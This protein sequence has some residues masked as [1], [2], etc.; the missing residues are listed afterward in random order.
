MTKKNNINPQV[1][2]AISHLDEYQQL[3]LLEFINALTGVKQYRND[4]LLSYVGSIEL[5][6]LHLMKKAIEDCEN[7]DED[8]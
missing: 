1:A 7:V 3:K 2:R 8:E 6:E 4:Q 5:S